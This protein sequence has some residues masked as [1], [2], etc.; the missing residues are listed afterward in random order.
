MFDAVQFGAK[1]IMVDARDSSRPIL[2][3]MGFVSIGRTWPC[4]ME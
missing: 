1:Y 4:V 2:E 3:R